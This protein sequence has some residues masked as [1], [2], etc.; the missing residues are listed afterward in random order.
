MTRKTLRIGRALAALAACAWLAAGSVP[1]LADDSL[2]RELG[3]KQG[4]QQFV[5]SF[6]VLN[7]EDPR[8]KEQFKDSDVERLEL[9]LT[10]QLCELAGGPCQY[11]GRDM[12]TLHQDMR[13]T[14][15]DFNAV[16]ENLQTAME[17][18]GVPYR[19]QNR[20]IAKLAPMK[21]DIVNH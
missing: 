7:M 12:K 16:A 1:A 21:R 13:V 20:L 2:F 11:K 8:L 18:A 9:V 4:I 17:R 10:E 19:A 15:A 3:G 5:R 14:T 6:V